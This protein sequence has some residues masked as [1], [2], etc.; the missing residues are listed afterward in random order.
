MFQGSLAIGNSYASWQS[1]VSFR[2]L[3]PGMDLDTFNEEIIFLL[4]VSLKPQGTL[5]IDQL[6]RLMIG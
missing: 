6:S 3:G 1:C 5:I 4:D 2:G